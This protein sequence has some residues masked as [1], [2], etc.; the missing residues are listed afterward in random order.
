MRCVYKLFKGINRGDIEFLKFALMI[1]LVIMYLSWIYSVLG[2]TEAKNWFAN[3]VTDMQ[4][5]VPNSKINADNI[6]M[7]KLSWTG[8]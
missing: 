8:T 3:R 4:K 1:E 5:R 6:D 2:R 7:F